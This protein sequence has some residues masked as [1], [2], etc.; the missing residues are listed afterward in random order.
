M[1]VM[2]VARRD[3]VTAEPRNEFSFDRLFSAKVQKELA[4]L[5]CR[6]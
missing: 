6:I 4:P 1:D 3:A 5:E 2:Y